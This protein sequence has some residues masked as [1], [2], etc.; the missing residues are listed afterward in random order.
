MRYEHI[1]ET[2]GYRCAPLQTALKR[3]FHHTCVY[4][5]RSVLLQGDALSQLLFNFVVANAIRKIHQ[6]EKRPELNGTHKLLV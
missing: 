2:D 6:T 3:M 5:R 1:L 4:Y